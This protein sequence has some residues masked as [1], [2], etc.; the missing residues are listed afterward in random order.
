MLTRVDWSNDLKVGVPLLD[1]EHLGLVEL[2]NDFIASALSDTDGLHL[3]THFKDVVSA[4][5][6]HFASEENMLDRHNYPRF[7]AHK[8][9]HHR[10]LAQAETLQADWQSAA[11]TMGGR[12]SLLARTIDYF[13]DRLLHHIREA[14]RPYRPFLMR[15][16]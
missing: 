8:A 14:D 10:L 5:R 6:D 7:A 13:T 16:A 1:A 4:V 15:L 12:D 9:H 2:F 11:P 3:G